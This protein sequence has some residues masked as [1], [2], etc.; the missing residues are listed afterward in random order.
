M[1][2]D[3]AKRLTEAGPNVAMALEFPVEQYFD[4]LRGLVEDFTRSS[5]AQCIY[6]TSTV[7]ASTIQATLSALQMDGSRTSFI[8]CISQTTMT[9]EDRVDG[10]IFVE[11]PTC[12][13]N[14]VLK[15]QYL[16][17]KLGAVPKLVV[18][19]SM[20]S[21]SFH[22]DVKM[23]SEFLH[24][25]ISG[26]SAQEAYPVVLSMKESLRP[27]VREMLAL[28]CDQMVTLGDDAGRSA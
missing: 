25:L 16:I 24:I 14:I 26:L 5:G 28:V 13:E 6:V 10:I 2:A 15:V 11:S 12:L 3:V 18:L 4:V 23:L 21:L 22:N 1:N 17:R 8:D 27:E 9:M 7:P 20:N 19:D